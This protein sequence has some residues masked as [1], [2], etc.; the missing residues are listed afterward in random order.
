M[1]FITR[2]HELPLL[3]G[4]QVRNQAFAARGAV[5]PGDLTGALRF[6]A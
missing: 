2:L 5:P 4:L 3:Q 1:R 6:R